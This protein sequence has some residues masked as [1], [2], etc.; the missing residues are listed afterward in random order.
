MPLPYE[1][2]M[3]TAQDTLERYDAGASNLAPLK[4]AR[5]AAYTS[6]FQA[7]CKAFADAH[8]PNPEHTANK[9]AWNKAFRMPRHSIFSNTEIRAISHHID[10]NLIHFLQIGAL[11]KDNRNQ[12]NYDY[13]H[14]PV[15]NDV[16]N[17]MNLARNALDIIHSASDA[18]KAALAQHLLS[19][20]AI[21]RHPGA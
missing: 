7:L 9:N 17:E 13:Y 3:Q 16:V 14:T 21:F 18:D 8:V 11:L 4:L 12:A 2:M 1:D 6:V 10:A 19:S 15:Y 20:R 5:H